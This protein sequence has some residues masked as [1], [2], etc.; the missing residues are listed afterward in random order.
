MDHPQSSSDDGTNVSPEKEERQGPVVRKR[1][2]SGWTGRPS[3]TPTTC[4][5]T[6][7]CERRR[8]RLELEL[9]ELADISAADA[10]AADARPPSSKTLQEGDL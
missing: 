1:E 6:P 9:G 10:P 2:R 3:R 8:R 5:R 7:S 4:P